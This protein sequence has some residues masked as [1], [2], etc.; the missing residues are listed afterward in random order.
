MNWLIAANSQTFDHSSAFAHF[1]TIEWRQGRNQY[2]VGDFVYIYCSRPIQKIRYKCKVTAINKD[3]YQIK[4]YSRYW[5]N[6]HEYEKSQMGKF[7]DLELVEE[8]DSINLSLELLMRHGLKTAPQGPIRINEELESYLSSAF[9]L[10]NNEVFPEVL[11]SSIDIYEGLKK[12]ISVNKY[13]RSALAR[14]RCI[15]AHG[16]VC[17]VCS[18]SFEEKYGELGKEFIH[19]HHVT[20]IHTIGENYKIDFIKDLVP[21]CPNCHAMLHRKIKGRYYSVDELAWLIKKA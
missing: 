4:D 17:K 16:C 1:G 3:F 6:K 5:V 11:D 20:P 18:F 21:V 2:S 7:F 13:E 9:N 15:E 19:V 8:V 12:Q 14:A 10:A